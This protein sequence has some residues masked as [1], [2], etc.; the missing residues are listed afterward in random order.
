M[1]GFQALT[2]SVH[3]PGR[4]L[5]GVREFRILVMGDSIVFSIGVEYEESV[6]YPAE[7]IAIS[8]TGMAP[9]QQEGLYHQA[10]ISTAYVPTILLRQKGCYF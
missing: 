9:T 10:S 6:A 1:K 2:L 7:R 8:L 3:P 4:T 5:G